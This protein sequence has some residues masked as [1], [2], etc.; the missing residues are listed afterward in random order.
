MGNYK[1]MNSFNLH[2]PRKPHLFPRKMINRN[3]SARMNR[4][5]EGMRKKLTDHQDLSF[6]ATLTEVFANKPRFYEFHKGR[7]PVDKDER[8]R[9]RRNLFKDVQD[10]N[11]NRNMK[12]SKDMQARLGN[13]YQCMQLPS[14]NVASSFSLKLPSNDCVYEASVSSNQFYYNPQLQLNRDMSIKSLQDG[15][16]LSNQSIISKDTYELSSN[17]DVHLRRSCSV[18]SQFSSSSINGS[19]SSNVAWYEATGSSYLFSHHYVKDVA[20]SPGLNISNYSHQEN[21]ID[22]CSSSVTSLIE[23]SNNMETFIYPYMFEDLCYDY[24]E[25]MNDSPTGTIK[26]L[27]MWD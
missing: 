20:S 9:I 5:G 12:P 10:V 25:R 14:I 8:K 18:I 26:P 3:I 21:R 11:E 22:S 4:V 27:Y 23:G 7:I 24:H 6:E 19:S 13:S 1:Q 16:S 2:R 15:H 17:P